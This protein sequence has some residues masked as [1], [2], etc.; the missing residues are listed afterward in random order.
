MAELFTHVDAFSNRTFGGNPAGVFLL[1]HE[2]DTAWMQ[3]MARETNLPA[4]AFVRE[5]GSD[6]ME[7]RWFTSK[8]ELELCGHGTLASAHAL[9]REG[10]LSPSQSIRFN[11]R[12][13]QL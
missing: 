7:L 10:G 12:G 4:T 1:D 3:A 6:A 11:T 8:D 2:R 5:L 13:G 9:W